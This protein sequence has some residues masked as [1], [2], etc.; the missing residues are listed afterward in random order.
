MGGSIGLED[1]DG[2]GCVFWAQLPLAASP[3]DQ[4]Q[5]RIG[6]LPD[7]L[8]PAR[9]QDTPARLLY[10]EGHDFDLQLLERLLRKHP[11]YSL[12]TAMQGRIGLELAR[13]H[14]PDLILV[15]L[16]LPDLSASDFLSLLRSETA[17]S[18]TPLVLLST[19]REDASLEVLAREHDA[20]LLHKPYSPDDLFQRIQSALQGVTSP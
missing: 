5:L 17:L 15:D 11:N 2:G 20:S 14:R 8:P 16:D 12:L 19:N 9:M 18:E 4:P 7:I 1:P 6:R 10:I 3:S 13:E